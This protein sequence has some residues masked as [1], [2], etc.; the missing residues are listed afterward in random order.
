MPSGPQLKM[1]R[2]KIKQEVN[3]DNTS[4]RKGKDL[5]KVKR[6]VRVKVALDA[7]AAVLDVALRST[8]GVG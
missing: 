2:R 1:L 8:T 7:A 4:V 6:F 3:D 5:V